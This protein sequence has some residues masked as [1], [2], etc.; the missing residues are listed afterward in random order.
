[1][2]SSGSAEFTG[3][4]TAKAGGNIAGVWVPTNRNRCLCWNLY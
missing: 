3:K 1:M 2:D 4:I